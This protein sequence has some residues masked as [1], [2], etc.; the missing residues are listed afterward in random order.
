MKKKKNKL[1][2]EMK[3]KKR[4][5][6]SMKMN[7]KKRGMMK[8]K[9]NIYRMKR[10]VRNM[11]LR[12]NVKIQAEKIVEKKKN[13]KINMKEFLPTIGRDFAEWRL[14][15]RFGRIKSPSVCRRQPVPDSS[16]AHQ[17]WATIRLL[18]PDRG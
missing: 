5:V 7:I 16:Q 2:R 3:M 9:L 17:I 12:N 11:K 14:R 1:M 13:G 6:K 8:F 4:K 10:N 18:T 15:F